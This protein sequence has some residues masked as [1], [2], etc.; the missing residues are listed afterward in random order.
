MSYLNNT[1]LKTAIVIGAGIAGL[2]AA[3][4]L[5]SKGYQVSVFEHRYYAGGKLTQIMVGDYRFDA[6]PSIFTMPQYVEEVFSE[7]GKNPKDY[8]E[9]KMVD[10][11][12]YV[13]LMDVDVEDDN[14]EIWEDDDDDD[15]DLSFVVSD[16]EDEAR[17][18]PVDHVEIDRDWRNWERSTSGGRSF[19][20]TVDMIEARERARLS[21]L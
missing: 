20:D 14:S 1:N 15:G 21:S 13:R 8:F 17:D 3:A 6:G 9:Y 4:R 16:D 11:D 2:A 10:V 7:C 18:V 5:Q 19:K 12:L